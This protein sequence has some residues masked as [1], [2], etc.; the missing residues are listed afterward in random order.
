MITGM[1][2]HRSRHTT[3]QRNEI[4]GVDR[5]TVSQGSG[6][7]YVEYIKETENAGSASMVEL[8]AQETQAERV[9]LEEKSGVKGYNYGHS[10]AKLV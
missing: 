10:W 6:K 4:S 3:S 5:T 7:T 9:K 8:S 2:L 1:R